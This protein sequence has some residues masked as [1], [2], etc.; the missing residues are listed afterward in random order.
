M[1]GA[2]LVLSAA[3][4][5]AL[6]WV[7][8]LIEAA[9]PTAAASAHIAT[10][11][12]APVP[13]SLLIESQPSGA[14]VLV[15][16]KKVGTTPFQLE[17]H[18][19]TEISLA[20]EGYARQLVNVPYDAPSPLLVT[21]VAQPDAKRAGNDLPAFFSFKQESSPRIEARADADHERRE[22][23]SGA[24]RSTRVGAQ[25][26]G[27][28]APGTVLS[29]QA[30]SE[31]VEPELD[32]APAPEPSEAADAQRVPAA[33]DHDH[34]RDGARSDG[35]L[36]RGRAAHPA[37]GIER[38]RIAELARDH[39][40][41]D[42]AGADQRAAGR[43]Y[44]SADERAREHA[45][46]ELAGTDDRA[47]G[48]DYASADEREREA[49]PRSGAETSRSAATHIEAI[50]EDEVGEIALDDDERAHVAKNYGLRAF[51]RVLARAV[52]RLLIPYP[53][54]ERRAVLAKMPLAYLSFREARAAYNHGAVDATGFQEAVWQLRERR[55]REI[56]V[57]RDRY[58]RGELG[59]SQYEAR[60][61]RIW[62]Q[63]WGNR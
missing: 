36:A 33:L 42:P 50:R 32:T 31:R 19:A 20:R 7:P 17:L 48:R 56:W 2:A 39:T 52:G 12:P 11:A 24:A 47:A 27:Q 8:T 35:A 28:R 59:Q 10:P 23:V 21:L 13:R 15:N 26:Q 14:Y 6:R 5:L 57:E 29:G 45:G 40:A 53:G 30:P 3:T 55:R 16:G 49:A 61:D 4:A 9:Q 41:R 38:E 43:D 18:S 44:A 63:F 34:T 37:N 25:R 62:E 46:R 22:R 54:R 58:A 51:G 1:L 60:I